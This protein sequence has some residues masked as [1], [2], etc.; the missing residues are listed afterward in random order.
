MLDSLYNFAPGLNW[1][2]NAEVT[3]L[4]SALKRLCDERQD[5]TV[6]LVD[7]APKPSEA[8]RGRHASIS[9]F[10][11][12]YKAASV[13]CSVALERD[14]ETLWISATGNNVRGFPRTL[15][16]FDEEALELRLL[17]QESRNYR[18]EALSFL[19]TNPGATVKAVADGIEC[20]PENARAALEAA[21]ADR[22][23][24]RESVEYR[25]TRDRRRRR[26]GW[27]EGSGHEIP[28]LGI[29]WGDE[30]GAACHE[31]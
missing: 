22:A 14:G 28:T 4:Y 18:E 5:V 26:E 8:T 24:H 19:V 31:D 23:A 17:E 2:D 3:R 16:R 7:H 15:C 1:N 25:D 13:R 27:F 9:S 30:R 20:R 10:G 12:V 11:S 21:E 29:S 6:V